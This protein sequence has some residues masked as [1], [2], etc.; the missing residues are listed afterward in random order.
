VR[1]QL[2]RGDDVGGFSRRVG[3]LSSE[4]HDLFFFFLRAVAWK[5]CVGRAM[6]PPPPEPHYPLQCLGTFVIALVGLQSDASLCSS[7]FVGL[8]VMVVHHLCKRHN[9]AGFAPHTTISKRFFS[10]KGAWPVVAKSV[11]AQCVGAAGA[12]WVSFSGLD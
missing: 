3:S 7:A 5:R 4:V 12:A 9:A 1:L 10:G 8:T 11:A 6:P 2:A